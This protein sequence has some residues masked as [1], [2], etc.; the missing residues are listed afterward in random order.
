MKAVTVLVIATALIFL[1]GISAQGSWAAT[2]I[3]CDPDSCA[4]PDYGDGGVTDE[5]S[6]LM[7]CKVVRAW[8]KWNSWWGQERWR[9][10]ERVRWCWNASVIT[11]V[12]RTRWPEIQCCGWQFVGH[13]GNSC[14]TEDCH[15]QIDRGVADIIAIGEF[16]LCAQYCVR[17]IDAGVHIRIFRGGAW[18][19]ATW[20]S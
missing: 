9:Y 10:T 12:S 20:N 16:K 6:P 13:I 8:R 18:Q 1:A 5:P 4:P 15:E 14:S 19:Y 2:T 17:T 11:S 3:P 7:T